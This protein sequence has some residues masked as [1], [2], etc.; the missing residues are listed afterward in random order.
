MRRWLSGGSMTVL[1]GIAI[2]VLAIAMA[3]CGGGGGTPS[4]PFAATPPPPPAPP[5]PPPPPAISVRGFSASAGPSFFRFG[6][7]SPPDGAY[8]GRNG[9]YR[10]ATFRGYGFGTL[11]FTASDWNTVV[12]SVQQI[13]SVSSTRQFFGGPANA[14][15]LTP[16]SSVIITSDQ[17]RVKRAFGLDQSLFSFIVDRDVLTFDAF[18]ELSSADSQAVNDAGRMFAANIRVLALGSAL[19]IFDG[20]R[21]DT[22][23][24]FNIPQLGEIGTYLAG[25]GP[26]FL[27]TNTN[28]SALLSSRTSAQRYRP[29]VI[30]AAAHLIDAYVA[31]IP[32]SATDA[33]TRGRYML[34]IQGYLQP[35]ME[36][37]VQANTVAAANEALA[38]T[39]PMIIDATARYTETLPFNTTG[40]LFPL[41][42]FYALPTATTRII[43]AVDQGFNGDGPL[44]A[45][46]Q[47]AAADNP[48]AACGCT[49]TSL[50]IPTRNGAEISAILNAD[51][52]INFTA[53][54][55]FVGVTYFDYVIRHDAT[56]ESQT[57]RVFVRFTA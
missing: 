49:L 23:V 7:A 33:A 19:P 21:V 44:T 55:N 22:S 2:A 24:A 37:L 1:R 34:G 47:F 31:A 30:S 5:P 25:R 17:A 9:Q 3:S 13:D 35:A 50:S 29:E 41:T 32:V 43:P 57:G 40:F 51:K 10:D 26:A 36:R 18:T 12:M 42:D 52:S 14:R 38:V 46:D 28:L 20:S 53:V 56:G 15:I 54:N 8:G 6:P 39:S 27:F 16:L 4:P 48:F 11:A 45:N